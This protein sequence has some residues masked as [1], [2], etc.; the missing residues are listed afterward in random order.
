[1]S[2]KNTGQLLANKQRASKLIQAGNL[3]EAK[4]I[5]EA[6]CKEEI[7]D[8][9]SHFMLGSLYGQEN[10]IDSAIAQFQ[11]ALELD[12]KA[13]V[14]YLNLGIAYNITGEVTQAEES[15][16]KALSFQPNNVDVLLNLAISLT[17]N[18]NTEEAVELLL[19]ALSV[20][21]KSIKVLSVLGNIYYQTKNY[22]Q[23][24]KYF[25]QLNNLDP[26]IADSWLNM[27]NALFQL[28]KVNE[29]IESFKKVLKLNPT[30]VS[31]YTNIAHAYKHNGLPDKALPAY[32]KALELDIENLT[33]VIGIIDL[34]ER[35]GELTKAYELIQ[36]NINDGVENTDLAASYIRICSKFGS[37]D[38]AITYAENVLNNAEASDQ[39]TAR[40]EYALGRIFDKNKNYDKAF[41]YYKHANSLSTCNYSSDDYIGLVTTLK[42]QFDWQFFTKVARPSVRSKRPIFILGMPRSGTSLTEQ[43]LASHPDIY[44][45]GELTYI[46]DIVQS[47]DETIL[48][49]SHYPSGLLQL[50]TED[51]D[52]LAESYL[53]R[54]DKIN[55]SALYIT[56][57]MPTNFIHL[58]LINILFPDAKIVHCTRDPIDTCLS[59]YFQDF[60]DTNPF[61]NNI[62][63][64]AA[65]YQQYQSFVTHIKSILSV[66]YIEVPYESLVSDQEKESRKLIEFV[67]LDWDDACLSFNKTKRYVATPSYDQ[68]RKKIYTSSVRRWV[69]YK[70]HISELIEMFDG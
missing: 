30:N 38:S 16:R 15:Y 13:A 9:E 19:K 45:A 37:C 50:T 61:A 39:E 43:I 27:G 28:G 47:L 22:I 60:G 8:A 7:A 51:M 68:V 14:V 46:G 67:G 70:E 23:A 6:I 25:T 55:Q 12:P 64:I 42:K 59:I 49:N 58:G 34:Y 29:S 57:K 17:Q 32:E 21:P 62:E 31:A 52:Q 11:R 54:L 44:G 1:M 24:V 33:A 63:D 10:K 26:N 18:N 5:Y 41:S 69:H 40:L 2:A 66:N 53:S 35:S 56:D 65:Y 20:Q 48:K 4:Q 36:Q 3:L